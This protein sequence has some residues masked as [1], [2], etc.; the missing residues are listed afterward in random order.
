MRS[1]VNVLCCFS[2]IGLGIAGASRLEAD[3][4]RE[5]S[6]A[7]AAAP[8]AR[9]MP[10]QISI[11]KFC[12]RVEQRPQ[13]FL[14]HTVLGR[15]YLKQAREEG[16]E[17]SFARA[18]EVLRQA[19]QINPEYQT[20]RTYLA[21]ALNSQHKFSEGLSEARRVIE[22]EPENLLAVATSG[23]AFLEL[24]QYEE[25]RGIYQKLEQE[26]PSPAV[27]VRL[28]HLAELT[29]RDEEAS[30]HLKQALTVKS[31]NV[32][33][34]SNTAVWYQMRLATFLFKRNQLAEAE[35]LLTSALQTKDDYQ[36]ALLA[37]SRLCAAQGR[38]QA[39]VTRMEQAVALAAH[40]DL[41][42]E[43]ASL[44]EL[45]GQADRASKTRELA[46]EKSAEVADS[47]MERRH[48]ATFY[49]DHRVETAKAV[50]LARQDLETRQDIY[51]WDTLAWALH[52]NGQFQEASEAMQH[53]LKLG[54]NDPRLFFHSGM[55]ERSLGR[56][57]EAKNRFLQ[58]S[59]INPR[60][61]P[62]YIDQ[63]EQILGA[64]NIVHTTPDD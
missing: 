6:D 49:A 44:Y 37:I 41:L 13:D 23:D 17:E 39:A 62:I 7:T 53:A 15:L 35:Q 33:G 16:V 40:F 46:I 2:L 28:A 30:Q 3:E 50:K 57:A 9:M 14:S 11:E 22:A 36:P 18:E 63:I 52:Q 8:L 51:A 58:V 12:R 59:R 38:Y 34:T 5:T 26:A 45:T 56:E 31:R 61:S 1:L 55:I 24:G 42:G 27:W 4:Q 43:L 25:A 19:L 10:L 29:G 21:V 20:A 60:F 64:W 32:E 54:T 47:P 48:L